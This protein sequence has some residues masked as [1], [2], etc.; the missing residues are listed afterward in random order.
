MDGKQSIKNQ[1]ITRLNSLKI[2][3]KSTNTEQIRKFANGIFMS[4]ILYGAE[5]WAGA[6]KYILKSLQHLQLDAARTCIG[7][8]SKQWSTTHL[9]K[10]MKWPS[11]QMIAQLSSAKLTHK[12]LTKG[13]PETIHHKITSGMQ[14]QRITRNCGPYKLGSKPAH[15]GTSKYSKYQ[16][17]A[18]SYRMYQ[19]IPQILKEIKKPDK[20]K[21]R[22]K[23]WLMNNDDLPAVRNND[24]I[25]PSTNDLTHGRHQ[26]HPPPPI[27]NN[28][29]NKSITSSYYKKA[30]ILIIR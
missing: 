29:T 16:Y 10:T 20:F 19:D 24:T 23:R 18:N 11:I 26:V 3:K 17:L 8:S 13:V 15:I 5:V 6:P 30:L 22:V 25:D 2:L 21:Q 4:K 1:L 7:P 9:L 27:E 12:I 28:P 14:K